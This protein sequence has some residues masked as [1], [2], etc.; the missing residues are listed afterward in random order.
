MV[1]IHLNANY[2]FCKL[3]KNKIKDKMIMAYQRM[4]DWMKLAAFRLRHH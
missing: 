4:V 3:T 1:G 2:I